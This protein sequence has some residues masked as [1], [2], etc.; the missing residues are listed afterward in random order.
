M[1]DGM[2]IGP[3]GPGDER[4][5]RTIQGTA[6]LHGVSIS[7]IKRAISWGRINV[8]YFGDR[9]IIPPEENER[10]AREGLPDIPP[11]YRRKTPAPGRG[12][13][14]RSTSKA[15]KAG[16]AAKPK[17]SPAPRRKRE[18]ERRAAAASIE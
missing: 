17:V 15:A 10:I 18:P 5:G 12:G 11:G 1:D 7:L 4:R 8:V 2:S 3:R 16:K 9:P 13:R 14:P 6:D